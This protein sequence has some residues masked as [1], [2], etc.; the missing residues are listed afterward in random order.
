MFTAAVLL[1]DAVSHGPHF[2]SELLL[3]FLLAVL[4]LLT[5]VVVGWVMFPVP[6]DSA[7][8]AAG[9]AAPTT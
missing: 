8:A 7:T 6:F 3:S 1:W 5:A 9:P 4:P 2:D